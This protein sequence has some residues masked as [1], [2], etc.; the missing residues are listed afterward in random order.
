MS[1]HVSEGI[2]CQDCGKKKSEFLSTPAIFN[3]EI[4][5]V[6]AFLSSSGACLYIQTKSWWLF[7]LGELF[8][9]AV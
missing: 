2:E 4:S 5:V 8:H 7:Y 1:I 9:T 3:S 6:E